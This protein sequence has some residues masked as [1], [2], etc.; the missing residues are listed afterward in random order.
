MILLR[1]IIDI[2]SEK[3]NIFCT[4]EGSSCSKEL[5]SNSEM[6]AFGPAFSLRIQTIRKLIQKEDE[7]ELKI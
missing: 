5:T 7:I 6:T 3:W 4:K 2:Y 1:A